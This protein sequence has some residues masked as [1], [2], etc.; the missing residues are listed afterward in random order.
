MPFFL[1]Y[2]I[3]S[4]KSVK[5]IAEYDWTSYM[6]E[7][8]DIPEDM[9]FVVGWTKKSASTSA[10]VKQLNEWAKTNPDE[11]KRLYDQIANLVRDLVPAW[12]EKNR[13]RI[14][15]LISRNED[16]LRELGEN[17]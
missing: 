1:A 9:N 3:N 11:Y 16:Y 13:E 15:E 12:K 17:D 8:L 2:A 5:E 6:V 14:L 10:M 7:E 4:G